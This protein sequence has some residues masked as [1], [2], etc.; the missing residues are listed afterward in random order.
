[1]HITLDVDG[2]YDWE[3][4]PKG[5]KVTDED[6]KKLRVKEMH[7]GSLHM[8]VHRMRKT[9]VDVA[10]GEDQIIDLIGYSAVKG[11][12]RS[13]GQVVASMLTE[14]TLPHHAKPQHITGVAVHDDGPRPELM[15]SWAARA[16]AAGLLGSDDAD[17]L[18][19]AYA[20]DTR[21]VNAFLKSYFGCGGK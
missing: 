20:A 13:R 4:V 21:D 14:H 12:H 10:M 9:H 5:T 19:E 3:P 17:A 18:V 11:G 15:K 8:R 2:H 7:D 16:L 6:H 1:M